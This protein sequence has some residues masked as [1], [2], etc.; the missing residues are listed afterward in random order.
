VPGDAV[1]QTATPGECTLR[2]AIQETNA[3]GGGTINFNIGGGGAHVITPLTPLPDVAQPTNI[4]GQ[5]QPGTVFVP[6]IELSGINAGPGAT[7]CA[8]SVQASMCSTWP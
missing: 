6:N 2:A 1:C 5:S 4:N 3:G 8:S 7:G